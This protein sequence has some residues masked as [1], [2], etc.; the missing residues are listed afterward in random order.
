LINR[1]LLNKK[2]EVNKI[3]RD[4]T[5]VQQLMLALKEYGY[6]LNYYKTMNNLILKYW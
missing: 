1:A 5:W 6:G 2:N 4:L 3:F